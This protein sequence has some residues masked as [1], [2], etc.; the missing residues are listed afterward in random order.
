MCIFGQLADALNSARCGICSMT[1]VMG[2]LI[3]ILVIKSYINR[4]PKKKFTK[5]KPTNI[6]ITGGVQGLGKLLA[7]KFASSSETG[8]VNLIVCDIRD[9]LAKE[10]IEDVKTASGN[11]TFKGIHFYKTNLASSDDVELLWKNVTKDHGEIH[12][13]I[14]NAARCLGKRVDELTI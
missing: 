9:D 3:L 1:A 11:K 12:V 4:M 10:L 6:L 5:E 13:L 8:S 14:N 7:E 2:L